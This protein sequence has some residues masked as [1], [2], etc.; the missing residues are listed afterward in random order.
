MPDF[1]LLFSHN[2][3]DTQIEEIKTVLKCQKIIPL[4]KQLQ[5]IWSNIPPTGD[6]AP[7]VTEF[8]RYLSTSSKP[9]D[10]ILI[11]GDFGM[12]FVAANWCLANGRIPVYATTKREARGEVV[13]G[14]TKMTHYFKHV[15]FRKYQKIE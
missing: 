7:I 8:I 1:Y 14:F 15:I 6:I 3:T 9:D 11:E 2:L 12:T 5:K 10:Y 13:N 4:P